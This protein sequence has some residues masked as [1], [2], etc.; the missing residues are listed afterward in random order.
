MFRTILWSN[1]NSIFRNRSKC[2]RPHI[3]FIS[4]PYGFTRGCKR[5]EHDKKYGPKR[6]KT[7][8]SEA[9]C[10]RIESEL[11]KIPEG[12]ARIERRHH[13]A[14]VARQAVFLTQKRAEGGGGPTE[15][16]AGKSSG[17]A[18]ISFGGSG[19]STTSMEDEAP[20]DPLV[21]ADS[22][23]GHAGPP[24]TCD[25]KHK[26]PL[27]AAERHSKAWRTAWPR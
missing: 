11:A 6:C 8:H 20:V 3:H 1:L 10:D 18:P 5:C 24:A 12:Q 27:W 4:Q 2:V 7:N 22:W 19:P 23:A 14:A 13:G 16:M 15:V 17:T 26:H 21:A 9:C 25:G